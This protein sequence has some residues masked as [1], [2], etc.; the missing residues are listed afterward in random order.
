MLSLRSLGEEDPFSP[1]LA[2]DIPWFVDTILKSL[3]LSAHGISLLCVSVF[4][5]I[6]LFL[7]EQK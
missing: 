4:V 7:Y 5:Q 2:S 1:L 3:L 6:S